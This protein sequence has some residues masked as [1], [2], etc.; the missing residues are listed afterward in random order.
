[1]K[2][3]NV[4]NYTLDMLAGTPVGEAA[5]QCK[6]IAYNQK[7]R[8]FTILAPNKRIAFMVD[9]PS[10][11]D[12]LK[13]FL[14]LI[15]DT[16][17]KLDVQIE[18]TEE[19]EF[20][21]DPIFPGWAQV[22]ET[23][24]REYPRA[25]F[26]AWMRETWPLSLSDGIL[27][28]GARNSYAA[29]WLSERLTDRVGNLASTLLGE[30]VQVNFICAR[31]PE[32]DITDEDDN[33]E[34]E[35]TQTTGKS[36]CIEQAAHTA[37]QDEV[38]T[39]EKIYLPGY[40]LRLLWH[41][42]LTAKE[43]SL[44]VAFRQSTY[45]DWSKG[46][47]AKR[48]IPYWDVLRFANM[49]RVSFERELSGKDSIAGNMVTIL[50]DETPTTTDPRYANA[51]RYIVQVSPRLSSKDC[52]ALHTILYRATIEAGSMEESLKLIEQTLIAMLEDS[53]SR[54]LNDKQNQEFPAS[55]WPKSIAEI[56]RLV[57]GY[58]GDMPQSILT[59]AE[60][61]QDRIVNGFGNAAISLYYLKEVAPR[62]NLSQAQMW[63]IIVLRY[64]VWQD[65]LEGDNLGYAVFFG[66][67]DELAERVGTTLRTVKNWLLDP[68]FCMLAMLQDTDGI[69]LSA[70]WPRNTAIFDVRLTEPTE[71]EWV[72]FSEN[73][74]KWYTELEKVIHGTGKS[75][76]RNW[77]KWY[78]ELEKVIH[79]FGKS[80]TRLKRFILNIQT[81]NTKIH[82]SPQTPRHSA[83]KPGKGGSRAYWDWD[84]LMSRNAVGK[85]MSIKLLN[86][87]KTEKRDIAHLC[88][89]FVSWILYGYSEAGR[90][91][92]SPVS[93]ALARLR[94]N[95][96]TGAGGDF[97]RLAALP[98]NTLRA[99][100]DFDLAGR[101]LPDNHLADAYTFNFANLPE[102]AK[103][104]L[105]GRLFE[106]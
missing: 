70:Q 63:A 76:T 75:D 54:Y 21:E 37:Y 90:G 87:N 49:S 95:S 55:R 83:Q 51:R 27:T 16:E 65:H 53:P 73:W 106:D 103:R 28:I 52:N 86:D 80:D 84:F 3:E 4:W 96:Y 62:L 19:S 40:A 29:E 57:T 18:N 12:H 15:G 58:K 38:D 92:S 98:P 93:N 6:P 34:D 56:V 26:D 32:N 85:P 94:E 59:A 39:H 50:P 88:K 30:T 11:V 33:I 104:E 24:Q 23:L 71:R 77:K 61:L 45:Y 97:D 68:A 20:P 79:G 100:I 5:A 102:A 7:N 66:G 25:S 8:T 13:S 64:R 41:G 46:K 101:D 42:D 31:P 35:D 72:E 36:V 17:L 9:T 74:K 91:L 82:E 47:P 1:M 105:R 99:F 81:N 43:M 78:M 44:W 2:P 22:L 67:L 69:E 48:N 60:K 89:K 14:E 10:V